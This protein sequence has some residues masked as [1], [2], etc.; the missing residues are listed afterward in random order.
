MVL[1][2][3]CSYIFILLHRVIDHLIC[4]TP[5]L[6]PPPPPPPPTSSSSSSSSSSS[7][8]FLLLLFFLLFLLLLFLLLLFLLLL[9][10][11]YLLLLFL[12]VLFLSHTLFSSSPS[13]PL[14]ILSSPTPLPKPNLQR[15][16]VV[17]RQNLYIHNIRDMKVS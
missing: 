10:L 1:H 6:P 12:F 14:L 11:L 2:S 17:L 5:P 16:V 13:L 8:L 3:I 4:S 9:Y 15:L 7:H